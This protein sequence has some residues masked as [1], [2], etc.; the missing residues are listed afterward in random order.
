MIFKK[1]FYEKSVTVE[2]R[3][4][5]LTKANFAAVCLSIEVVKNKEDTYIESLPACCFR[6]VVLDKDDP[7]KLLSFK[8]GWRKNIACTAV[9]CH[10]LS[11]TS[12]SPQYNVF[13]KE[14]RV[15]NYY[16]NRS[17]I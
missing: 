2:A 12:A 7:L 4:N 10:S 11:F 9:L 8:L 17:I 14:T 15:L 3:F 1:S 16:D 13:D 6:Q 5:T